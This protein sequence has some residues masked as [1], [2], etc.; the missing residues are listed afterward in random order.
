MNNRNENEALTV[1]GFSWQ[2]FCCA[3]GALLMV[4]QLCLAAASQPMA[5]AMANP[6]ISVDSSSPG[7]SPAV[8]TDGKWFE[9]GRENPDDYSIS[10]LGNGG[11]TWV[12]GEGMTEHWI[13]LDWPEPVTLHEVV[14][15][16]SLIEWYPRAFRL[17]HLQAGE[18]IPVGENQG[19]LAAVDR[20]SVIPLP[21]V[22]TQALRLLQPGNGGN[23]RALLAAQEIIARSDE[24]AGKDLLGARRLSTAAYARL[25]PPP[26]A[27]NISRLNEA[28]PGA[29]SVYLRSNGADRSVPAL[30]DGDLATA[31]AELNLRSEAGTEWTTAH[32]IDG[33]ALVFQDVPAQP[34][35]LILEVH[36]GRRWLPIGRNLECRVIP[37]QK[38]IEWHFEPLATRAIRLRLTEDETL[39]LMELEVFRY[40]PASKTVW[41]ER[42]V[43]PHGLKQ[44]ILA[45]P[46]EPSFEAL[47]INAL[48]MR[49]ARALLGLKDT[50]REVGVGWE[51]TLEGR[52]RIMFRFGPEQYGLG[53]FA[54]S[55]QRELIDGWRPGTVV[56]GQMDGLEV[57][58]TALVLPAGRRPGPDYLFVHFAF[59]NLSEQ[60]IH[61][62]VEAEVLTERPGTVE[63]RGDLILSGSHVAL[64]SASA[65]RAG[66]SK[67]AMCVDIELAPGQEASTIF[68]EPQEAVSADAEMESY[69]SIG[70]EQALAIFRAYWD[71]VLATETS[72]EVPEPRINRTIKAVLAQVFIN[73]DGDVMPYGSAPSVYEGGL[74]GVE[75]GYPILALAMFGYG[76]DAQRYLNGTYLTDEFLRKKEAYE[77]P[78]DRHQ[79]YRNGLQPH[80]AVSAFRLTRDSTWIRSHLPLLKQCAEWTSA[81]RRTTMA[82]EDGKRPLHWGLLPKWSY[83]GD[84][85]DVQCYAF[86]AN[87]CC[88]RGLVDTAWLLDQFG[89]HETAQRYT[90]EARA[91]RQDIDRAID[92][93]YVKDR[94]PSFL[95]LRLYATQ[96]DEQLDFYQ[97]FA[98]CI[99]DVEP[100]GL[101][102]THLR[103]IT[104]FLEEDN[105]MFC[106][107]PR[108]RHL[109]PGALDAIYG[110][111]YFLT[112]LHQDNIR[113]FLLA[114]YAYLA[115]NMEQDVFTSRESNVLYT[116]DLH[117][118]STYGLAEISDPLP[119]GSAVALHLIR[120]ILVT[121]ERDDMGG[122][123]GNLR[124]LA[125]TPR[126]WLADG[127]TIRIHGAPTHFGMVN[128]DVYSQAANGRIEARVSGL[129]RNACK[130]IQLRLRHP[131]GKVIQSVTVNGKPHPHFDP[132]KECI[133]LPGDHR[134]ELLVL[135]QY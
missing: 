134:G 103:W 127:Q 97:L 23:A 131:E 41:P 34:S 36:D 54:D 128:L 84:I 43:G 79:Q 102:S 110:K 46:H 44:E 129:N 62:Y 99:L 49:T 86:Y 35:S 65:A 81:Q 38:R 68:L 40:L 123:S 121:E 58:Q 37:E 19:W 112:K 75:E 8:L 77:T 57:R 114:L 18:W 130:T 104:D 124:L 22:R 52:S 2:T 126:A 88:W 50:P 55:V 125:G 42:L 26:L 94:H 12:S 48:S 31:A 107:L 105:R 87:L 10:R 39:T 115:F 117:A 56:R 109:G 111:G 101:G 70:L 67:N 17:E 106:L 3:W 11:N 83:G 92:G 59:R 80:Y 100:F 7:Y 82:L 14:I 5:R 61:T 72:F 1:H 78:D 33:A 20:Q 47:A 120:H 16:W 28:C 13:R 133:V 93:S 71:K 69:R 15:W 32:V 21:S 6:A 96:P 113:E 53:E 73:G 135:T 63:R 64:I 89:D 85:F 122:Y 98:G 108:F 119:C 118:R 90:E 30:A 25:D 76:P 132:H 60:H 51:G 29:A 4:T 27:R 66:S 74:F 45:S 24:H 116:S 9:K 91:Y 95:P